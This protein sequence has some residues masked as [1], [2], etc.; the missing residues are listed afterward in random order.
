MRHDVKY[1]GLWSSLFLYVPD[2]R[3]EILEINVEGWKTVQ[4]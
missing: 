4:G 2:I 3:F 1:V